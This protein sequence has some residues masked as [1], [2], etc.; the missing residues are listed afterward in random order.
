MAQSADEVDR[1]AGYWFN[2]LR[3]DPNNPEKDFIIGSNLIASSDGGKTSTGLNRVVWNLANDYAARLL[4]GE[5]TIPLGAQKARPT[6]LAPEDN[7]RRTGL[8]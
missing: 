8:R 6:S 1:K 3:A 7:P 4:A 5:Y 2:Q